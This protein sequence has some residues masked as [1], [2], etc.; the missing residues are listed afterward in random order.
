MYSRINYAVVGFFVLLFTLLAIGFGFWLAQYSFET[1][2]NDYYLYFTEPVDGLNIDSSVMLNGVKVGKV[3]SIKIDPKNIERIQVK[4]SLEDGTPIVDGMY[5]ILKLQGIT[6]LSYVQ[7]EGGKQGSAQ[8]KAS[9][10]KIPT[11]PTKPSFIYQL[12]NNAPLL[13]KKLQTTSDAIDKIFSKH[14]QKQISNIIDNTA[15]ITAQAPKIEERLL[16]LLD[17]LKNTL[18]K[19]NKN[20]EDITNSITQI[21]QTF[22]K[23]LPNILNNVNQASKNISKVAKGIDKR[24]KRGEYD[25]RKIIHPIQI[26]IKELSY[27]YQE[28]SEDLKR[29]SQHPSSIIFGTSTPPKGP[30]E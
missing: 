24:L 16:T 30:G 25:L 4:I 28:L 10:G 1:D 8:L 5:A 27:N 29:L 21:S 9:N 7:I 22:N 13:L 17:D 15:K 26:D 2:S 19:F 14:N 23:K 12:S 6:G 18:H 11:I 20:S 3:T